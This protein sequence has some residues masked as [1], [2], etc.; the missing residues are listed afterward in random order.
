[1]K[2][3]TPVCGYC[4]KFSVLV[5][6][7]EV[8]PHR[9]DLFSLK[10]YVCDP[11]GARVGVHKGTVNPLGRLANSEL[12][13]A[14]SEAHRYFDELWKSKLMSRKEAYR[15]L[16]G[17]LGIDREDCHIGMFDVD[18]CNKSVTYALDKLNQ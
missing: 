16:S 10:F 14:K 6:G 4:N 18:M 1:M 15:W 13:S 8:Y 17:K 5:S 3:L 11:C 2:G 7:K 12:R 9:K